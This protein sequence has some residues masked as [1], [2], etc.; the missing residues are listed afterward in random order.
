[1]GTD[2]VHPDADPVRLGLGIWHPGCWTLEVTEDSDAG[3]L[4]RE[5]D[6][7]EGAVTARVTAYGPSEEAVAAL[8]EAIET[9][10]RTDD[11]RRLTP[12][13]EF[14]RTEPPG[15]ATRD[16][17]VE[18]PDTNSIYEP[19]LTRRFVPDEPIRI[20]GGTEYWTV[21]AEGD[22]EDIQRRLDEVRSSMD[23]DVEVLRI[24]SAEPGGASAD[25]PATSVLSD[26]QREAIRLAS[27]RGYYEWPRETS[28]TELAAELDV[29]KATFLEHLRKAE[30]KLLDA[31]VFDPRR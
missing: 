1:M 28:A 14:G 23:A 21:V 2:D 19:F 11:V 30:A 9:S 10:P 8:V 20:S 27:R 24:A 26:R 29:N 16:L 15:K 12:H 31:R 17:L 6:S 18:Y 22:R 25:P 3:M 5:V 7:I 13:L 4:A